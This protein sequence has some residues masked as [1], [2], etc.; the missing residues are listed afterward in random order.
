VQ[1]KIVW[2]RWEDPL[3][4]L[5]DGKPVKGLAPD[6]DENDPDYH[7]AKD[8][9]GRRRRERKNSY[10]GPCLV[11]PIGVVP[12]LESNVPSV[13]FNFWMG[14]ATVRITQ[15]VRRKIVAVDG[16]ETIDVFSPYRFRLGVGAAF[17]EEEVK[18]GIEEAILPKPPPEPLAAVKAK[19]SKKFKAWAIVG[20]PGGRRDYV[21]GK[22]AEEVALKLNRFGPEARVLDRYPEQE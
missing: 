1:H 4:P 18:R 11:G 12:L 21:G 13:L 7:A 9:W 14:H 10:N 19:L 8:S 15:N 6:E 17:D 16:V 20:L 22:D 2:K 5:L 3:V